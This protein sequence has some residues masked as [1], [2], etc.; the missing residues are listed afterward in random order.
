[1]KKDKKI[2]TVVISLIIVT[3]FAGPKVYRWY[4][5]YHEAKDMFGIDV[6][7]A[8]KV[9]WFDRHYYYFDDL[10]QQELFSTFQI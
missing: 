10:G 2:L 6:P 9:T 8:A 4:K 7:L 3:V 5:P 1:M